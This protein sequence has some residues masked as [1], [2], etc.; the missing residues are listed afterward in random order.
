MSEKL[1]FISVFNF[2]AIEMAKNHLISLRNAGI[3]NHRSYVTDSESFEIIK[4]LGYPVYLI[5][6]DDIVKD[7]SNFGTIEFN[8]MSYVRYH[9]I[10]QLF[11]KGYDV[12]YMDVDT[13]VLKD[14][15]Y[16]YLQCKKINSLC[17]I[18]QTDLVSP[19][20][21]CML[22]MNKSATIDFVK[23]VISYR[24]NEANDQEVV[25]YIIRNNEMSFNYEEFSTSMF[26]NGLLYFDDEIVKCEDVFKEIKDEYVSIENKDT[27]FVHANWIVGDENKINALKKYG[28]WF[29]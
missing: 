25:R 9:V 3:E 7:K 22:L 24:K 20:T 17:T 18:F 11:E 15:T 8:N 29:I 5:Q 21:G 10:L 1:V 28:L 2:G 19:C 6:N 27:H 14:L 13:V 23:T 4:S 16:I 12:W 26:P